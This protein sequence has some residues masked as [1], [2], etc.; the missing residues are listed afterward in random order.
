MAKRIQALLL[1]LIFSICASARLAILGWLMISGVGS[2]IFFGLIHFIIHFYSMNNLAIKSAGNILGII[3]SHILFASIILFQM[4]FDDSRGYS[5]LGNF[6]GFKSHFLERHGYSFVGIALLLYIIHT[7]VMVRKIRRERIKGHNLKILVPSIL[8]ALLLPNVVVFAQYEIE[9]SKKTAVLEASGEFN[10][11]KRAV[12]N[13]E[14]VETLSIDSYGDPFAEFPRGLFELANLKHLI[15]KGHD[16]ESIPDGIASL[17]NLETL[18]LLDNRLQ[19]INPS[20]CDCQN[21]IELRVG[22]K[23]QSIPDCLKKMRSLRHLS[24]QSTYTNELLD[25]L[26]EFEN[27]ETAHFYL[28]TDWDAYYARSDQERAEYSRNSIPFDKKKWDRIK[29]ETGIEHKY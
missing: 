6:F 22:G 12:Q 17:K 26:R 15:L 19:A 28:Y 24:F 27:L 7:V 3:T 10:S 9:E 11:L 14:K 18:N 4:D 20:I 2:V 5:V 8:L 21:L 16:I 23:I 29:E 1:I 25:E 13:P